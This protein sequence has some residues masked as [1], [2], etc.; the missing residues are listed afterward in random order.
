MTNEA[1][2]AASA[3]RLIVTSLA[4][5]PGNLF[6]WIGEEGDVFLFYRVFTVVTV[7]DGREFIHPFAPFGRQADD[8]VEAFQAKIRARGSIDPRHWDLHDR[9][10]SLEERLRDEA[11]IEEQVRRGER[12][13]PSRA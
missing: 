7:E 10:P 5:L 2:T 8:E 6:E 4:T 12:W 3:A 13:D 9:G 11:E 1:T